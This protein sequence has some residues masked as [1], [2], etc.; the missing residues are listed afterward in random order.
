MGEYNEALEFLI[1][2][3]LPMLREPYRRRWK[4]KAARETYDALLKATLR[5][6]AIIQ[7]FVGFVEDSV[8]SFIDLERH[9]INE[10]VSNSL[11]LHYILL[12]L[13]WKDGY[14][15]FKFIHS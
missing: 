13:S 2:T 11:Q 14:G 6:I 1:D 15:A 8:S 3:F 7:L 12:L 4:N 9:C 10:A 5:N